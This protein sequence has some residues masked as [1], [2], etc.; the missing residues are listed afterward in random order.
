MGNL[1]PV[2]RRPTQEEFSH[3]WQEG[4]FAF[5]ANVLLNIY[6]YTPETRERFFELLKRLN[7]RIWIPHQ[8]A[9]EF[10]RQRLN[11]VSNQFKVFE[12]IETA[13]K[14]SLNKL[15]KT[16]QK[17]P[18]GIE[19]NP[20]TEV[21]KDALQKATPILQ[22]VTSQ[23]HKLLS[24]DPLEE[25]IAKLFDSKVGE[26]YPKSELE[27]IYKKAA[28]RFEQQIPPG[29]KDNGK[30][31][32]ERYGDAVIWF[33]LLYYAKTQKKSMIFITDDSKEDWWLQHKGKTIGPRPELI[34]E[35]SFEAG[36][37][38]HIYSSDAFVEQAQNFLKLQDKQAAAAVE[39]V[40]EIRQQK[41]VNQKLYH[42]LFPKTSQ[43]RI[44]DILQALTASQ[45]RINFS[46]IGRAVE[47]SQARIN[48]GDIGRAVEA[49]Q[50]SLDKSREQVSQSDVLALDELNQGNETDK[51]S[52]DEIKHYLEQ[53][54]NNCNES[55]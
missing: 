24:F 23:Y 9:L 16:Q 17:H 8:T 54:I 6:R 31:G 41:E 27:K 51:L 14:A 26:P 20:L 39:E 45:A 36:V 2:Y 4:I 1:L 13:L 47:A 49:L 22:E 11:E 37:S 44:G 48:F 38:F 32:D 35:M 50:S 46:D 55:E 5:D 52:G 18:L 15:E 29:Y 42:E 10:H 19:I 12:E 25:T 53:E 43:A 33:Q 21:I 40:R 3:M 28:D 7:A 30:K 34:Q